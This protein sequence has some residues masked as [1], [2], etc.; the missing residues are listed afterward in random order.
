M[1]NNAD[2]PGDSNSPSGVPDDGTAPAQAPHNAGNDESTSNSAADVI[3]DPPQATRADTARQQRAL[4]RMYHQRN[5]H[6]W[7]KK[8]PWALF[9]TYGFMRLRDPDYEEHYEQWKEQQR[10]NYDG[11]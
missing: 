2:N 9:P 3:Y 10:R 4:R 11:S 6:P 8:I 1:N 5:A 7:L